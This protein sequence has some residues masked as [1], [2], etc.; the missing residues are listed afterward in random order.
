MAQKG[1]NLRWLDRKIDILIRELT[2]AKKIETELIASND[3]ILV[4]RVILSVKHFWIE[5]DQVVREIMVAGFFTLVQLCS[6]HLKRISDAFHILHIIVLH[7][8]ILVMDLRI[9]IQIR[10]LAVE[11]VFFI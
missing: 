7:F 8:C 4:K 9:Q 2:L 3:R 10:R 5:V 1:S 6:L 11:I